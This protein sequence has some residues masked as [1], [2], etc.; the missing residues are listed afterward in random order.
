MVSGSLSFF[1]AVSRVELT[2][3]MAIQIVDLE[4]KFNSSRL[5]QISTLSPLCIMIIMYSLLNRFDPDSI[6]F[7]R[8]PAFL[9]AKALSRMVAGLEE[10]R[11]GKVLGAVI[12]RFSTC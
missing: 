7:S 3:G 1:R 2:A 6:N 8:R 4:I 11:E 9:A 10:D 5:D 12:L